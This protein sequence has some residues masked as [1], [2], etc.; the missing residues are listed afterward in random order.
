MPGLLG[1]QP[2]EKVQLKDW[3]QI[4]WEKACE[5]TFCYGSSYLEGIKRGKVKPDECLLEHWNEGGWNGNRITGGTLTY[6][7]LPLF[8]QRIIRDAFERGK[9]EAKAELRQWLDLRSRL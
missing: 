9:D 4:D 2:I 5:Y 1:G 7:K 6:Y 8:I 3:R